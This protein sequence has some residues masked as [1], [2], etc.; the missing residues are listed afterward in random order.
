[1]FAL[2][3]GKKS[4]VDAVLSNANIFDYF[5]AIVTAD[6]VRSFKC[7]TLPYTVMQGT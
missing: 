7:Q 2:S 6:D 5:E 1:M 4:E 3:N